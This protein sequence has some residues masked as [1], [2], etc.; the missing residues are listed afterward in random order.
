MLNLT[1]YA[2]CH[3]IRL[4]LY[5]HFLWQ[6]RFH[7]LENDSMIHLESE[8]TLFCGLALTAS[9]VSQQINGSFVAWGGDE[10]RYV[11]AEN[12]LK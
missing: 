9:P 10:A 2:I 11:S 1:H 3:N 4:L 6:R 7:C 5:P 8:T 12:V